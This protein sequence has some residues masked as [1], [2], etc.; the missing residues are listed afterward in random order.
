MHKNKYKM[1][2]FDMDG[3][4]L[5]TLDDLH[6]AVSFALKEHDLPPVSLDH[7]RMVLGRGMHSYVQSCVPEGSSAELT[8]SVFRSFRAYYDEHSMDLTRPYDGIIS[9]LEA[10]Q[11]RGL[12][13]S[14]VSNKMD[15]DVRA[16]VDKF[17]ANLLDDCIGETPGYEK[18]PDPDLC[19]EV[20]GR[21]GIAVDECVYV[22]DTEVDMKTAENCGMDLIVCGWG[23]RSEEWLREHGAEEVIQNPMDIIRLVGAD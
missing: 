18:K 20:L 14:C 4:I 16:L 19:L 1:V 9:M 22:G 13:T 3:T 7:S 2:M 17:Y 8:E 5:N 23:F 10:L 15:R 21:M 11:A 6:A 12:K